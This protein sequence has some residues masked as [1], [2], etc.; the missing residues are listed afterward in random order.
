[1]D[2]VLIRT[3][4]GNRLA[5]ATISDLENLTAARRRAG[6]EDDAPR[7]RSQQFGCKVGLNPQPDVRPERLSLEREALKNLEY[8]RAGGRTDRRR[9]ELGSCGGVDVIP[10][11]GRRPRVAREHIGKIF[12]RDGFGAVTSVCGNHHHRARKAKLDDAYFS[13]GDWRNLTFSHHKNGRRSPTVNERL[14]PWKGTAEF[15]SDITGSLIEIVGDGS[16]Q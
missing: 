12:Q 13:S 11:A 2:V 4:G 5:R 8:H 9:D 1:M 14:S 10:I 6:D 7:T 15:S 16:G 3:V